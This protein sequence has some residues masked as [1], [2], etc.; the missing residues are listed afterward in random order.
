MKKLEQISYSE[1]GKMGLPILFGKLDHLKVGE[2]FKLLNFPSYQEMRELT[3][4]V[5]PHLHQDYIFRRVIDE[6]NLTYS[7][8]RVK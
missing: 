6:N 8:R 3:S 7:V 2:G 4:E 1:I 5:E